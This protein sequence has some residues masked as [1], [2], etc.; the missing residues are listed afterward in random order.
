MSKKRRTNEGDYKIRYCDTPNC[1]LYGKL[2]ETKEVYCG[3][4]DYKLELVANTSVGANDDR[5]PLQFQL[6]DK[7]TTYKQPDDDAPL[8]FTRKKGSEGGCADVSDCPIPPQARIIIPL[9]LHNQWVFL[10][11]TLPVEWI[12]HLKGS[13][14]DGIVTLNPDGMYFKKQIVEPAHCMPDPSIVEEDL[15]D[16]IAT[17]HSHVDM[18]AKFSLEDHEHFSHPAELVVNKRG[19]MSG[20]VRVRLGCGKFSRV[21]ATL[22]MDYASINPTATLE[23]LKSVMT[24]AERRTVT[25]VD[26]SFY[27]PQSRTEGTRPT[28][29]DVGN[30]IRSFGPTALSSEYFKSK[31]HSQAMDNYHSKG[32]YATD[33]ELEDV[34]NRDEF[35]EH[36]RTHGSGPR[37]GKWEDL[38][39]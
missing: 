38:R 18:L 24:I 7:A 39:S 16:T 23:A 1:P 34:R 25:Q 28:N 9:V 17:V 21:P 3:Q 8:V 19:A 22:T 36:L 29:G 30:S 5:P 26:R 2:I 12:A 10:A 31:E 6:T 27:D 11:Q 14:K 37:N 13:E 20:V 33:A 35:S 15:P 4:C 32:I